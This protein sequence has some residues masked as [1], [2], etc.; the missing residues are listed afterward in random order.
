MEAGLDTNRHGA[1]RRASEW[2]V[3]LS[4]RPDDAALRRRFER[5]LAADPAHAADWQEMARTWAVMGRTAPRYPQHWALARH[6]FLPQ[7]SRWRRRVAFGAMAAGLAA[8]VVLAVFPALRWHV[9]ADHATAT[10]ETET[11]HLADG[12]TVRLGP[13]SALD[14][15]DSPDGRGAR[16]LRGAAFFEVTRDPSRPFKVRTE[17]LDVTVLGTA[18]EARVDVDGASVAVRQGSVR[19]D[20][21]AAPARSQTL[22]AGDWVRKTVRG[23]TTHGT[24]PPA[25]VAAWLQGRLIVKDRPAGEV[26]D[27]LRSYYAG[28]VILRGDKLTRQPLTGVY[29]LSDPVAALKAVASALGAT[30]EQVSP[31]VL[32]ISGG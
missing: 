15:A 11:I 27:A 12:S 14:V 22:K 32:V 29:D 3:A 6:R 26:I 5:W 8:A 7:P 4:E 1:P 17:L 13:E 30:T 31:W 28:L 23:E 2:M 21:R 18:F 16:L 25:Q 20:G 24:Q 10:A 9:T 19:V